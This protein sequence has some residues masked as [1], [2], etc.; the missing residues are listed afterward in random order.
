MRTSGYV[1]AGTTRALACARGALL[2]A[3][4]GVLTRVGWWAVSPPLHAVETS[5]TTGRSPAGGW[6]LDRLIVAG[7]AAAL[8]AVI[9][10]LAVLITLNVVG[11][12]MARRSAAIDALA[13]RVSP[14]WLRRCVLGMCGFA[15]TAPGFTAAAGA[16]DV[17]A[18]DDPHPVSAVHLTGLALPDLPSAPL[19]DLPSAPVVHVVTVRPGDT[20]WSIARSGLR[21]DATDS[22]VAA[23]VT[24][25]SAANRK[26]IGDD[27]DLIF[28]GQQ[29][30]A[31]GGAR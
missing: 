1:S 29:L 22:A 7:A 4:V 2:V 30:I 21:A 3:A 14:A 6:T 27:P 25:L 18:D 13:V 23:E 8:V 5:L 11:A 9:A 12:A 17:G 10:I 26:V 15:L 28:P 31:P 16:H 20:L 24:A 19:P